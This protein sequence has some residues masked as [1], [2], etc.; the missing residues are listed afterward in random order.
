MRQHGM[1]RRYLPDK[2]GVPFAFSI[3]SGGSAKMHPASTAARI[4]LEFQS[5]GGRVMLVHRGL[6]LLV[7]PDALRPVRAT[8]SASVDE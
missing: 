7:T 1:Q 8:R 6:F 5:S 4:N 2:S 3:R